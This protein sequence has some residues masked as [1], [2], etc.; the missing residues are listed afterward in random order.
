MEKFKQYLK[1]IRVKHYIKNLLIFLPLFFSGLYNDINNIVVCILGFIMFSAV[2]SIVYV[3]NDICDVEKDRKHPQKKSRPLASGAVS[4][5]EAYI[6]I[7]LLILVTISI[8]LLL[9]FNKV[10]YLVLLLTLLYLI[11]NILYSKWL[12]N[13]VLIDVIILVC[14]FLIRLFLGSVLID[15]YVSNYLYLTVIAGAFY[16]GFGKRRNEMIKSDNSTRKVLQ[17]YNK[18]FLDKNM[19]VCLTLTIV[20]YSMWAMDPTVIDKVHYN[21]LVWTVPLVM[22]ILFQYSLIIERDSFGDPVEVLLHNKTLLITSLLYILIIF[23]VW[24]M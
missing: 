12:K 17:Y 6:I 20:F 3:I 7:S 5:K 8:A 11:L 14:G 15:T 4:I 18:D 23:I 10:S 1:L 19:Y 22:I 24:V 2:C 16:L 9:L 21:I 13:V